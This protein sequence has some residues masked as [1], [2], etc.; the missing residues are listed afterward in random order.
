VKERT[1]TAQDLHLP[2]A[3]SIDLL[4]S[5]KVGPVGLTNP[6]LRPPLLLT[7]LAQMAPRSLKP[8]TSLRSWRLISQTRRRQSPYAH[9]LP[10]DNPYEHPP[11]QTQA[12]RSFVLTVSLVAPKQRTK[13]ICHRHTRSVVRS[14]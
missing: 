4:P 2:L 14:G 13:H 5:T 8:S 11:G 1:P 6:T 7:T 3:R 9:Q 10:V 12:L